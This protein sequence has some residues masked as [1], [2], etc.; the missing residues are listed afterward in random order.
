[1]PFLQ[2]WSGLKGFANPPWNL[3]ARVLAETQ[4]Q[5]ARIVLIAPVWN[6]QLWYRRLLAMLVD[7][8]H[9]LPRQVGMAAHLEP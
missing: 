9:L 6:A 8:P 3:I 4:S 5:R 2:D 1:M 7:L